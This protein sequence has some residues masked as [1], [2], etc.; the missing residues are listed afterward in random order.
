MDEQYTGK[1]KMGFKMLSCQ[2]TSVI[3]IIFC[4]ATRRVFGR[5]DTPNRDTA[6]SNAQAWENSPTTRSSDGTRK[7]EKQQGTVLGTNQT[8]LATIACSR[9]RAV[10]LRRQGKLNGRKF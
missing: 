7:E 1:S 9:R 8:L 5:A 4:L 6:K 3:I 2:T 10:E